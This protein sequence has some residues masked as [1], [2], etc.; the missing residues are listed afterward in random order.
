M[1]DHDL[2][3]WMVVLGRLA[4][5]LRE[6]GCYR[7]SAPPFSAPVADAWSSEHSPTRGVVWFQVGCSPAS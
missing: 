1:T 7:A 5:A 3:A 6:S 2:P 4:V